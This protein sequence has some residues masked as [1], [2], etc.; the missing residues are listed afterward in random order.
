VFFNQTISS[1]KLLLQQHE[2]KEISPSVP[3]SIGSGDNKHNNA[4][5]S[6]LIKASMFVFLKY[7]WL[8]K[9]Y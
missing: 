1:L 9:N 3:L 6:V 8:C 2:L 5:A 4:L 7:N